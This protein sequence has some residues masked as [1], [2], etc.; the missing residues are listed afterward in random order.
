MPVDSS[1]TFRRSE[2]DSV[3]SGAL[4][5]FN[6]LDYTSSPDGH[7]KPSELKSFL[8]GSSITASGGIVFGGQKT[9]TPD[10]RSATGYGVGF[11]GGGI[12]P[13]YGFDTDLKLSKHIKD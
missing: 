5:T 9:V 13:S 4:L 2:H 1:D 12:G 11:Y 3:N 7:A 8:E 10:N 6:R